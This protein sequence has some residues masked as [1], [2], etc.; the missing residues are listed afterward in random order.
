MEPPCTLPWK[1]IRSLLA[2]RLD[3]I[4]DVVMLTPA[5][6]GLREHLPDAR[7]TLLGTKAGAK[8]APMLPWVDQ[9]IPWKPV[10]QELSAMPLDAARERSQ[11][12]QLRLGAYD[13]A[14]I[15][16]S[17]S[18]SPHPPAFVCRQAGIPWTAAQSR[19]AGSSLTH[20]VPPVGDNLHQS[21]RSLYLLEALGLPA[22]SRRLELK[23]PPFAEESAQ[24]LLDEA[25][26]DGDRPLAVVA[27]GASCQAR[28][29]PA[30]R[31]AK[32]IRLL[33]RKTGVQ[34]VVAGS[35]GEEGVVREILGAAGEPLQ[36]SLA[37]CS[38]PEM[39][40]VIRRADLL[41]ANNSSQLHIADAVMTPM[42]ILY[43]G[44]ETREQWSPRF[45]S[46]V[47]LRREVNCSPC[48]AFQCPFGEPDCL[49]VPPED[50]AAAA[51]KLLAGN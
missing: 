18:Q 15:F 7:I 46:A 28:R 4:G 17:F 12:D 19:E 36:R 29:Y 21:E 2:V 1:E 24:R 22:A 23:I 10:W 39:A 5:L 43:S 45:T 41:I 14:L 33:R 16:T 31:Y 20:P 37:G 30:A 35:E 42:V 50:V 38:V 40:A 49:D 13:A 6:R 26:V 9:V 11:I 34:V 48:H 8:V 3:N 47:L 25:G 51:E 44:T 32:A 27:P